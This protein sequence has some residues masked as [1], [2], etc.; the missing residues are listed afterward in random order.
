MYFSPKLR[1]K[2]IGYIINIMAE[3]YSISN[4]SKYTYKLNE[5]ENQMFV[6][7]IVLQKFNQK[8]KI[9]RKIKKTK[10]GN[11]ISTNDNIL[12]DDIKEIK[13]TAIDVNNPTQEIT[14]NV[15]LDHNKKYCTTIDTNIYLEF[16]TNSQ[17]LEC[18]Y[19]IIN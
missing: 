7:E 5:P 19:N 1:K 6:F 18:N 12:F 4:Q 14:V 10:K 13:L 15:K 8:N 17:F 9:I 2:Y 3:I 16:F 11:I